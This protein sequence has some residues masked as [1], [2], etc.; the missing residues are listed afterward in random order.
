M[1]LKL[2]GG[3]KTDWVGKEW[4]GL[5]FPRGKNGLAHSFPGE[6]TDWGEFWPVTPVLIW[7][8]IVCKG[9]QQTTKVAASKESDQMY[10]CS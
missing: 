8:Q 5:L 2:L 3:E 4:A 10:F 9:Y 1:I 6:K 7:V